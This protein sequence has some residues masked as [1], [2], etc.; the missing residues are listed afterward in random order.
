MGFATR[1]RYFP[2]TLHRL[3]RHLMTAIH[4]AAPTS[5]GRSVKWGNGYSGTPVQATLTSYCARWPSA[6]PLQLYLQLCGDTISVLGSYGQHAPPAHQNWLPS[7]SD[8]ADAFWCAKSDMANARLES[9]R[10]RTGAEVRIGDW[11]LG[12]NGYCSGLSPLHRGDRS[13]RSEAQGYTSRNRDDNNYGEDPRIHACNASCDHLN[14][15]PAAARTI[16]PESLTT[17]SVG[18]DSTFASVLDM[19]GAS[20][21]RARAARGVPSQYA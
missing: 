10:R 11:G 17:S 13:H 7:S 18:T 15:T 9:E 8:M 1:V 19:L 4:R 20:L 6:K 3:L 21:K 5:P 14:T 2:Q 12:E 16:D